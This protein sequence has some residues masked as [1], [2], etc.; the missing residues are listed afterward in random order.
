[1]TLEISNQDHYIELLRKNGFN[2]FPIPSGQKEADYCYK[3]SRTPHNQVIKQD[4][5]YGYIP[6]MGRGT[7][8]IDIDNKER[9]R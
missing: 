6:I 8:I 9:Y 1:M 2:C 5:N 7:A 4:E 3:A